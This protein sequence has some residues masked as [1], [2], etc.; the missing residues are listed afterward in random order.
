ML[1]AAGPRR[2]LLDALGRCD[3]L[4][5]LGDLLELRHG[6]LRDALAAAAGPLGEIGAALGAGRE[7]VLTAGNHDHHLVEDWTQRRALTMPP[8]PLGGCSEVDVRPGEALA[9]VASA[10]APARARAVYPGIWLRDDVYAIH[11]HYIDLHITVPTIERV[12]AA[13]MARILALGDGGPRSAEDYEL[14]LAPIYGWIGAV[15]QWAPPERSGVLHGGSVRG[16]KALTGP[17]RSRTARQHATA[18]SFPLLVAMLNRAR[19]GPLRPRISGPELRRT[20]LRAMGEVRTRLGIDARWVLFGHTHRAGPLP[21]DDPAEWATPGGAALVNTGCW[22]HEPAFTGPDPARSPYRPGFAV[23]V[24][25]DAPPR[26]V[27][28][29]DGQR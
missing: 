15:A 14:V 29:L 7:V 5:L 1:R 2:A 18:A 25:G 20:G 17:R 11:G 21:T 9:V 8:P 10:L 28:L 12:A 13:A 27:N 26:L 23:W 16:W 19:L 4:V 24:D 3:R 22:V 6:P